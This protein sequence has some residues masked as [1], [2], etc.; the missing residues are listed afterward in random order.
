M[1]NRHSLGV[2]A[3]FAGS[4]LVFGACNQ[5]GDRSTGNPAGPTAGSEG[6]ASVAESSSDSGSGSTRLEARLNPTFA[7]DASGKA[8]AEDAAG[9]AN[10]RFDGQVEIA[11]AQFAR[12]GIDAGDGFTDE[13]VRLVVSR[14]TTTV[15]STPLRFSEN[16][17]ADITFEV[18]I[19]GAAAPELRAGDVAR[20]SVNGRATLQ[21]AFQRN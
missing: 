6:N 2:W 9:T 15:F 16:R 11:K 10:D 8:R 4:M 20:V 12:V 5:G 21:G 18:D 7:I 19:R 17:P 1:G 14:G 3:L 13:V